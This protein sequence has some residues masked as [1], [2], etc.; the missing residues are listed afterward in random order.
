ML[1]KHSYRYFNHFMLLKTKS[2]I[3]SVIVLPILYKRNI[4][5][6]CWV[7]THLLQNKVPFFSKCIF[8]CCLF[9]IFCIIQIV[10]VTFILIALCYMSILC[11]LSKTT[12]KNSPYMLQSPPEFV[13]SSSDETSNWPSVHLSEVSRYHWNA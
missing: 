1:L 2:V 12:I 11:F 4:E 7:C 13:L 8:C 3:F 5:R 9:P 6:A 10:S